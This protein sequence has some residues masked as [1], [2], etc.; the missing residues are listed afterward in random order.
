MSGAGPTPRPIILV[1]KVRFFPSPLSLAVNIITVGLFLLYNLAVSH[2]SVI[3]IYTI[4]IS[5]TYLILLLLLT[6]SAAKFKDFSKYLCGL[7]H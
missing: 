4:Y 6:K 1:T 2:K 7:P 5:P 3:Y